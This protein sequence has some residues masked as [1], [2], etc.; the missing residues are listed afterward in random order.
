MWGW[1]RAGWSTHGYFG[2]Q[3]KVFGNPTG[4][5]TGNGSPVANPGT[6]FTLIPAVTTGNAPFAS[7]AA[8]NANNLLAIDTNGLAYFS[9]DGGLGWVEVGNTGIASNGGLAWGPVSSTGATGRYIYAGFGNQLA[10]SENQ[11]VTW[12]TVDISSMAGGGGPQIA[13]DGAGNWFI[14]VNAVPTATIP[15]RAVSN[16]NG[17]TWTTQ[18]HIADEQFSTAPF[19]EGGTLYLIAATNNASEV[20]YYTS[21]NMGV[22]LTQQEVDANNFTAFIGY[23]KSIPEFWAGNYAV[24]GGTAAGTWVNP[25]FAD[26]ISSTVNSVGTAAGPNGGIVKEGT[27]YMAFSDGSMWNSSNGISWEEG[28]SNLPAGD[29]IGGNQNMAVTTAGRLVCVSSLGNVIYA[30]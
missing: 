4:A 28:T 18:A 1:S 9:G 17:D 24:G 5:A 26:L 7:V 8:D 2:Q 14:G 30:T 3:I 29:S 20:T 12:T 23:N 19:W 27:Y 10:Y 13:T 21:A 25:T 6:K 11:G 15:N 22:T 16:D